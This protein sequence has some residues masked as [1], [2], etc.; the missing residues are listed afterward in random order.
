MEEAAPNRKVYDILDFSPVPVFE[1]IERR[2][3]LQAAEILGCPD[4]GH[5]RVKAKADWFILPL[6]LFRRN[7]IELVVKGGV[8]QIGDPAVMA[9]FPHIQTVPAILDGRP[10]AIHIALAK[11][12]LQCKLK[13]RGLEVDAPPK[14]RRFVFRGI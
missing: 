6:D 2:L 5:L 10:K 4:V 11:R 12:I 9:K 3:T 1:E 13:E 14:G 7:M 8:P